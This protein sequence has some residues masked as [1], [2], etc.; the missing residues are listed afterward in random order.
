M[1]AAVELVLED[2]NLAREQ[3]SGR[4]QAAIDSEVVL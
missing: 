2:C 1:S 3:R 4:I